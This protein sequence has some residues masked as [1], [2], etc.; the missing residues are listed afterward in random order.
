MNEL[1]CLPGLI[2][3]DGQLRSPAQSLDAQGA[4]ACVQVQNRAA[5]NFRSQDVEQG[6]P[7]PVAGWSYGPVAGFRAEKVMPSGSTA[8]Y[9]HVFGK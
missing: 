8:G 1:K 3:K 4:G 9:S 6:F 7:C 2:N 5:G